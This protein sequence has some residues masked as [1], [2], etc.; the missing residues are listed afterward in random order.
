MNL[1][2]ARL[3]FFCTKKKELSLQASLRIVP[4]LLT[5][6]YAFIL[7]FSNETHASLFHHIIPMPG[8]P[9]GIGGTGSLTVA[10]AA[11]VVRKLDA[12]DVAF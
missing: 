7:S 8:L 1:D 3:R 4:F 12:T 9:A 10:T 6:C 2:I 11:S 5:E